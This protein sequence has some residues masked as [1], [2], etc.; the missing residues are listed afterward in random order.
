MRQVFTNILLSPV[1]LKICKSEA[2]LINRIPGDETD[3]GE[4]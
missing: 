2:P 4:S 1:K 3:I